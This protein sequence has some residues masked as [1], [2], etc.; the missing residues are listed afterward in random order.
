[1]IFIQGAPYSLPD[2]FFPADQTNIIAHPG[3]KLNICMYISRSDKHYPGH[4]LN[5][6]MYVVLGRK[7]L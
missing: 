6:C 1:M 7:A 4:K 2:Q 3:H 5:V